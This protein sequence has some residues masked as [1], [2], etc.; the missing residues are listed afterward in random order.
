MRDAWRS[1][2]VALMVACLGACGGS[3]APAASD[4]RDSP[5]A[6]GG[7]GQGGATTT[8][9]GGQLGGGGAGGAACIPAP[10]VG[11]GWTVFDEGGND[12]HAVWGRSPS[13]IW[14]VGDY[15][16]VSFDG[17]AFT[18]RETGAGNYAVWPESDASVWVGSGAEVRRVTGSS[19]ESFSLSAV[20]LSGVTFP[21]GWSVAV[22][23]PAAIATWDT[24]WHLQTQPA[25]ETFGAV[26]GPTS[27]DFWIGGT[28]LMNDL[29][30]SSSPKAALLHYVGGEG[31]PVALPVDYER[32]HA[33][34][35]A[36]D[37]DIHVA[38]SSYR[39]VHGNG[40]DWEVAFEH[41]T[42][43]FRAVRSIH[44]TA[45]DDAWAV[46]EE[47]MVAHYDGAAWKASFLAPEIWLD[48]VWAAAPDDVWA[49]GRVSEPN[50][51]THGIVM[52]HR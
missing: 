37:D 44:G 35:G 27:S 18:T 38:L 25:E 4:G 10:P 24:E 43:S 48:S 46:G 28:P 52:R 3:E 7:G 19:V 11:S 14:I 2:V 21:S 50:G 41:P 5:D 8:G 40:T 49:V 29:T 9:A 16:V 1:W 45:S 30:P 32:V 42:D 31:S 39:I 23:Y 13:E 12:Y 26:W 33:I 20:V 22:G 6:P 47:G 51:A 15:R 36:A 17:C 34:W